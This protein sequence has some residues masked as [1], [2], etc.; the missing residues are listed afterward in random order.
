MVILRTQ[1]VRHN[2]CSMKNVL[3]FEILLFALN[4][5]IRE[6]ILPRIRFILS[7]S[8]KSW[9]YLFVGISEI[10]ENFHNFREIATNTNSDSGALWLNIRSYRGW[11]TFD[12]RK[13]WCIEY[14]LWYDSYN[15][16]YI[17]GVSWSQL[18]TRPTFKLIFLL[19]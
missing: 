18:G 3:Y 10:L 14:V 1:Q 13:M 9:H 5:R 12:T 17:T 19:F 15:M 4:T 16:G 11:V 2:M 7:L 8:I 6:L